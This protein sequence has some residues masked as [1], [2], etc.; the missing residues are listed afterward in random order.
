MGRAGRLAGLEFKQVSGLEWRSN[1]GWL[2][3][4]ARKS[5]RTKTKG[6]DTKRFPRIAEKKQA[7]LE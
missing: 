1:K 3:G 4:I 6:K 2:T 7:R 5:G